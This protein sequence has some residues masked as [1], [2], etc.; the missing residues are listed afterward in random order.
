MVFNGTVAENVK[1]G[2]LGTA[3]ADLPE[4]KQMKL[5]EEAC[6]AAYAHEFIEHL[7]DVRHYVIIAR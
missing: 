7:P 6:K 5:I 1:M 4:E 2:L 3:G